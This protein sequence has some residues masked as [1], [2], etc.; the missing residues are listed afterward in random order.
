M[1]L[2]SELSR[3]RIRSIQKLIR[4]G[5]IYV[6]VVIRVDEQKG[7]IDLSRRRVDAEDIPPCTERYQKSKVVHSIMRQ[8]VLP[9]S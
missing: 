9:G 8:Y 3:R 1:L 6:C 4:E 5:Q 2:L 7:Y